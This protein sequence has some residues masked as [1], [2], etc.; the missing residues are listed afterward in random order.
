MKEKLMILME[1]YSKKGHFYTSYPPEKRW[2]DNYSNKDYIESL[3]DL[4]KT[5]QSTALYLHFPFCKNK[6]FFCFCKTNVLPDANKIS[7]FLSYIEKE[8]KMLKKVF[9]EAGNIPE[10]KELHFGGG[11]PS[12]MT[13][14]ELTRLKDILK[15][16]VDFERLIEFNMEVDP[17]T[18][19]LDKIEFFINLGV[20][21]FSFGIQDFNPVVQ[22]AVN[23][24]HSFSDVKNLLPEEIRKK[25]RSVNFDIIYGLPYQTK[26]SLT[27]TMNKV[28]ELSPDRICFYVYVHKPEVY[29]I[30]HAIKESSLPN[31][32]TKIDFFLLAK[33][34]LT[35]AGYNHIGIEH[36]SKPSDDLSIALKQK[37]VSRNFNG[38]NPGRINNLLGIGPSGSGRYINYYSQ[39]ETIIEDYYKKLGSGEFPINRGYKMDED[40]ML[41]RTIIDG[42]SCN[43]YLSY[44]EIED[45]FKIR[46]EEY[47]KNEIELLEKLEKTEIIKLDQRTISI[48]EI[49]RFF[50]P[51]ICSVFDKFID[52]ADLLS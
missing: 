25:V 37:K 40:D 28:I 11:S 1:K 41:R 15:E 50:I 51:L 30:Q 32:S 47:F 7:E 9:I 16:I 14:E 21:R 44:S 5:K 19:D 18:A 36:F 49:G 27:D 8:V 26:E 45:K 3:K 48:T 10:I 29:S 12:S 52:K 13:K 17:R 31:L 24:I 42:I 35:K 46:F 22:K 39:N 2:I 23:R 38:Y 43:C 20:N 34:M 6:C 33:E 4:A